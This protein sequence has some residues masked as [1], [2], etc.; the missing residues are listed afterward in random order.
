[1]SDKIIHFPHIPADQS[2]T[3]NKSG[4]GKARG[5]NGSN[6]QEDLIASIS[7]GP[8]WLRLV[9]PYQPLDAL[10][11]SEIMA[12][13]HSTGMEL[14]LEVRAGL[15]ALD[16][17]ICC[18]AR[19]GEEITR[20]IL[21]VCPNW[22]ISEGV[23]MEPPKGQLRLVCKMERT[24]AQAVA[25]M[26]DVKEC[27][28]LDPLAAVLEA[29]QP[30][31]ADEQLL[32]R[33][34]VRPASPE[35]KVK[36]SRDLTK[37]LP[38][39][40]PADL[41]F[42]LMGME[43]R[44]PRFEAGLQKILERRM[45][46]PAFEV[47][48]AVALAGSEF[49]RLE[50]R[51]R[52]LSAVFASRFDG[53][54]GGLQL[55]KWSGRAGPENLPVVW[56]PE[57][58]PLY[59]TVGELAA[60]WHPPSNRIIVPGVSH[61]RRPTTLLPSQVEGASGILLGIHRQRG[62]EVQIRL[63]RR[64]LEAG[65][66]ALI[67]RTGVGKSTLEHRFMA[68]LVAAPDRPGLGVIDPNADLV[69]DFVLRS[70]PM[71][72]EEDVVYL[73]MSDTEFPVGLPFFRGTR[74][75]SPETLV[76]TTFAVLKLI[77]REHWSPTR[78]E[79]AAFGVTAAL[80]Q[81]PNATLLDVPKL[82]ADP[83]F[84]RTAV[85]QLADPVALEFWEEYESL[86][87]S[88]KREVAR[89]IIYRL[90]SFYRTRAVR[91][92]V[93]QT[94]GID[95]TEVMDKGRILL[96]SLAGPEIQAE[97]D[98]LGELIIAHL[99]MAALARLSHPKEKRRP[100]YLAVDESQ[101][102]QGASLPILLSEGRKLGLPL[103]LST[104]FFGAWS[105]RLS[106]SVLGNVG[107]LIAFR[108]GPADSRRLSASLKPYTPEEIEDLNRY[109]AIVKLQIDGITKPAFDFTTLPIDS[110]PDEARLARIRSRTRQRYA[111]PRQEVE[112]QLE[113][114]QNQWSGGKES[115]DVYEE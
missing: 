30:L 71:A 66:M 62:R 87:E 69:L 8:R 57:D 52:S 39:G 20:A 5:G 12:A 2:A 31:A 89:P 93:C 19:A 68:E 92:I 40:S 36:L 56:R 74:G 113:A 84:R 38:P 103:I 86:S 17:G 82:F 70:I 85:A 47:I 80:C 11:P 98:I 75:V 55:N 60:L 91:N 51:A 73:D 22:E 72:R 67:G 33:Y 25:P 88:A 64:D 94:S 44:V 32:I 34:L 3:D 83:A 16:V 78:M 50:S 112:K 76:Q 7:T 23:P 37:T 114:R 10:N 9:A 104:Q 59:V 15:G 65:H 46:Q 110:L 97:A 58:S 14:S 29:V 90:R 107:T 108:C 109:E 42:M 106:E 95:F 24:N 21:G 63:P 43:A 35:R 26:K 105:E 111:R 18:S 96:V 81:L 6:G 28:D 48:G 4:L 53:G 49:I 41:I 13:L 45:A 79:D 100:F 102:F 61:L 77:F 54:F 99:H 27:G 1:M 101:H 115:L